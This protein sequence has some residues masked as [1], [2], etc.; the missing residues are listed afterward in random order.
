MWR[1]ASLSAQFLATGNVWNGLLI[2]SGGCVFYYYLEMYTAERDMPCR[3]RAAAAA[4]GGADSLCVLFW[5]LPDWLLGH[6]PTDGAC[7]RG[8]SASA[9]PPRGRGQCAQPL[10]SSPCDAS[11]MGQCPFSRNRSSL[12]GGGGGGE[13]R[14]RVHCIDAAA[15]ARELG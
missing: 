9:A 4:W 2:R 5:R 6:R 8:S 1:Q 15:R 11:Y 14:H 3:E 13:Q 12:A 7:G 10:G